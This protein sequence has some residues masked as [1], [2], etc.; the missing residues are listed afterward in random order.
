MDLGFDRAGFRHLASYELL[1][2]GGQTLCAN[3]PRW[4]VHAGQESGDVRTVDWAPLKGRVDVLHGGPPCQPF[5]VAGKQQGSSDERDM[6]PEFVRAVLA[7]RPRAFVAENVPGLLDPKFEGYLAQSL[8]EPLKAFR[9]ASFRLNACGFGVP[10]KRVRV[11]FV[12]FRDEKAFAAFRIPQ[13]THTY[14]HLVGKTPLFEALRAGCPKRCMGIR[15]SL[16]LPQIGFD[17]LSPTLRSGFTGP[18]KTTSV[19]NSSASLKLWSQ[20]Q[21]WPHGVAPSRERAHLFVPENRHF[22][23]SVQ[24]CATI[25]GFPESWH[26]AGAVYQVLGQVGNSVSPP[27]A[28]QVARAVAETLS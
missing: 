27:V 9:I 13:D 26:F 22:R 19:V 5:S 7:T 11:F 23:L 8:F 21:I 18:R 1:Q 6:W 12:G 14:Q 20:L 10:Q 4:K 3:R 15:E 25:Q 2:V 24:D 17:A 28:Y 16:G